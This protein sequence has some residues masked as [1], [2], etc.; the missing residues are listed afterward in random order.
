[1]KR[2]ARPHDRTRPPG[3]DFAM[4]PPDLLRTS[5]VTALATAI[6]SLLVG[7]LLAWAWAI[8]Q[9]W[10]GRA[11]VPIHSPRVVPWGGGSVVAGLL[12]MISVSAGVSAAYTA[13]TGR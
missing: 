11:L 3:T 9:L 10:A 4:P 7:M 1:M 5:I 8:G 12:A 6:M 2:R 13:V